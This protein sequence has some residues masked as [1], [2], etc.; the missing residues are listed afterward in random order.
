M[1]RQR[2][3]RLALTLAMAGA[4]GSCTAPPVTP[5]GMSA[6]AA[7][8]ARPNWVVRRA[9]AIGNVTDV[10][11][12]SPVTAASFRQ[13]LEQSLVTAGYLATRPKPRYRLD[14]ALQQFDEP[15]FTLTG[16]VSVTVAVLYRLSGPG[17]NAQYSI[18]DSGAAT[19]DEGTAFGQ[20]VQLAS[21][22]AL[23]ANIEALL[24]KLQ[25]F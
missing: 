13:A 10:S 12:H 16:N 9:I 24:D 2:W 6:I 17:T 1:T 7:P 20:R 25:K 15:P 3:V 19:F 21:E 11:G 23:Q 14:A 5:Q 8:A 18:T 4:L 22:R